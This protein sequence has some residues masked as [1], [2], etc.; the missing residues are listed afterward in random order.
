MLTAFMAVAF[1]LFAEEANIVYFNKPGDKELNSRLEQPYLAP[2][3]F[4]KFYGKLPRLYL[5]GMWKMTL[6]PNPAGKN[7]GP[8]EYFFDDAGMKNNFTAKNFDDSA[9][10]DFYVPQKIRIKKGNKYGIVFSDFDASKI[11]TVSFNLITKQG[12][13]TIELADGYAYQSTRFSVPAEQRGKRIVLFLEAANN[14]AVIYVNGH[15]VGRPLDYGVGGF[16][17][18]AWFDITPWVD[19]KGENRLVVRTYNQFSEGSGN[20]TREGFNCNGVWCPVWLEFWDD[21]R[22]QNLRIAPRYPD[23]AGVDVKLINPQSVP[24]MGKVTLVVTP[25][26]G[27]FTQ[28]A[29][30]KEKRWES[31]AIEVSLKPGENSFKAIIDLPGIRPWHMDSPYLYE[32]RVLVDGKLAGADTFGVRSIKRDGKKL[33]V[34]NLPAYFFGYSMADAPTLWIIKNARINKNGFFGA[35]LKTLKDSTGINAYM[36]DGGFSDVCYQICDELG[37][38]R[39]GEETLLMGYSFSDWENFAASGL[40]K[41][42]LT[43]KGLDPR[44][45]AYFKRR[46]ELYGNHPAIVSWDTTTEVMMR[47]PNEIKFQIDTINAG[48]NDDRLV[49][50]EGVNFLH[51]TY[52]NYEKSEGRQ[53]H[54]WKENP[55]NAIQGIDSFAIHDVLM[56]Y[57]HS[58]SLGREIKGLRTFE[59]ASEKSYPLDGGRPMIANPGLFQIEFHRLGRY[60]ERSPEEIQRIQNSSNTVDI[61]YLVSRTIWRNGKY[62]KT[63]LCNYLS[64][65]GGRERWNEMPVLGVHASMSANDE[66]YAPIGFEM[67][68]LG[69]LFRWSNE[70]YKGFGWGNEEHL[71]WS[72]NILANR[73]PDVAQ[74]APQPTLCAYTRRMQQRLLP[75]LDWHMWHNLFAGESHEYELRVMNDGSTG[76]EGGTVSASLLAGDAF[77][78]FGRESTLPVVWK[79]ETKISPIAAGERFKAQLEVKLPGGLASGRYTMALTLL[80]VNGKKVSSNTYPINIGNRENVQIKSE[81]KV[82]LY[83]GE[84]NPEGKAF[85]KEVEKMGLKFDTITDFANIDSYQALILCPSSIDW[86]LMREAEVVH[87]WLAKGG[88]MLC[89]EQKLI[90]DVPFLNQLRMESS[91]LSAAEPVEPKHPAFVGFDRIKDM[92]TMNGNLGNALS[93]ILTPASE[94]VLALAWN[95]VTM[96][97]HS[98]AR[99]GMSA[100]EVR[101]GKGI[102]L[103]NQILVSS[104]YE[105]DP[106]AR[107]FVQQLLAYFVSPEFGSFAKPLRGAHK[108]KPYLDDKSVFYIDLKKQANRAFVD[109]VRGDGKGGWDDGGPENDMRTFQTG[110]QY[111]NGVPYQIIEPAANDGKACIVLSGGTFAWAPDGAFGIPVA[112]LAKAFYFLHAY[113]YGKEGETCAKYVV[114]YEDGSQMNIPLVCGKNISTWWGGTNL[115][116]AEVAWS[117]KNPSAGTISVYSYRWQNPHPEKKVAT[118]DFVCFKTGNTVPILVAITGVK[119]V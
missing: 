83:Y 36:R 58:R 18:K 109:D 4:D 43:T 110:R 99:I 7:F 91:E 76:F 6:T 29:D 80:D 49:N 35:F 78:H 103:M 19:L 13:T 11:N 112:Q 89:M 32:M 113:G 88:R 73:I 59:Q 67:Q 94:S 56:S 5:H 105:K 44:L 95:Q 107:R 47:L 9:W 114:H 26:R 72:K 31:K 63:L 77:D 42:M 27:T 82:A 40:N 1:P 117:G 33:L 30:D 118:I 116:S 21:V 85:A 84:N 17:D 98:K 24:R 108:P 20:V 23:A 34:N 41:F 93:H 3:D 71:A 119:E 65:P 52:Q 12:P 16:C 55:N 79:L 96:D 66:R 115:E 86:T 69:E 37:L 100:A 104:R 50:A 62:D 53:Y 90:G 51:A 68:R 10:E 70:F 8:G 22:A 54:N 25:W 87:T 60:R 92:D 38:A 2:K 64:K 39:I 28:V 46:F 75:V 81:S 15:E 106:Q 97:G 14:L 74:I 102:C 111:L 45:A 48:K 101:E 61:E 57:V